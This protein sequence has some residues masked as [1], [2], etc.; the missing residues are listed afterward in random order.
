MK[1]V[2]FLI[3]DTKTGEIKYRNRRTMSLHPDA[4][5]EDAF[6]KWMLNIIALFRNQ[7]QDKYANCIAQFSCKE[8]KKAV[9]GIIFPD[10]SDFKLKF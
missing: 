5:P 2:E 4:H 8:D 3:V 7:D 6:K 9:Q 10:Y 1:K